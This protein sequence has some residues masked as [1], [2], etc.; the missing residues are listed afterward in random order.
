MAATTLTDVVIPSILNTETMVDFSKKFDFIMM[1]AAERLPVSAGETVHI[2][3]WNELSGTALQMTGAGSY[4][5]TSATQADDIAVILHRLQKFGAED[6]AA[7]TSGQNITSA[8]SGM[9]SDYWVGQTQNQ[10]LTVLG[11][12][13]NRTSGLLATTN[14][15]DVFVDSTTGLVY[16]TPAT[17]AAGAAK[18]GDNMNDIAMWVMHSVTYAK[19]LAAGYL[20]TNTNVSAYGMTGGVVTLFMGKPVLISDNCTTFAGSTATGYR[21]YGIARGAMALGVQQDIR[22]EILRSENALD[23]VISQ[24]HFAPHVRGCKW[25][26]ATNPT[27]AALAVVGSWTLAYSSAKQVRVVAID[28][29]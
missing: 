12:L 14:K 7:V 25:G 17:A 13:F 22:T 24:F 10:L 6:L 19:L 11:S 4:P 20:E 15:N 28:H 2:R 29:N 18:I 21:T 9:L 27:D 1:G 8:I 16:F 5:V 26:G 23:L 3:Q